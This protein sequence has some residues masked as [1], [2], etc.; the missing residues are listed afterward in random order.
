[1]RSP[2]NPLYDPTQYPWTGPDWTD[3]A[4]SGF[5]WLCDIIATAPYLQSPPTD[6][7]RRDWAYELIE[8]FAQDQDD[9]EWRT[10]P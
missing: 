8:G 7:R 1:V 3:P 4:K 9:Y 6:K 2:T 5:Q 10:P